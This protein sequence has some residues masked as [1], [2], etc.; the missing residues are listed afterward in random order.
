MK[1][2][3]LTLLAALLMNC[4][5]NA[6]AGVIE[7][8]LA[9]PA[10]QALLGRNP[11]LQARVQRCVDPAYRKSNATSC[12]VAEDA[13]RLAKIPPEL[14]AVLAVPASATSIRELC[15][16]AQGTPARS[17]YLCA[18]LAKGDL[19]FAALAQQDREAKERAAMQDRQLDR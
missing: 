18:E 7:E 16:A 15:L 8:L 17:S 3:F 14:R 1:L 9:R 11:D 5:P 12:Q 19:G 6:H 4:M 10:I 2:R 13:H